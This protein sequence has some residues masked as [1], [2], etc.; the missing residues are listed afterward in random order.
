MRESDD[1]GLY[2]RWCGDSVVVKVDKVY[3]GW[4]NREGE[5]WTEC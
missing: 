5:L 3:A 1:F 2:G 4:V